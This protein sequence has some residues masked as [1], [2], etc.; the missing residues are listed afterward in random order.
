[1]AL[2]RKHNATHSVSTR[3]VLQEDVLVFVNL[4]S[5][6]LH[7][8]VQYFGGSPNKNVGD[9][10]LLVW[11]NNKP[12]DSLPQSSKALFPAFNS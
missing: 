5:H 12:V 8:N 2:P 3:Q 6:I 4:L 11:K 1:V 7:Q 9:A 10:F